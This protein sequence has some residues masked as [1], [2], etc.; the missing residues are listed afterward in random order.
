MWNAEKYCKHG[1]DVVNFREDRKINRFQKVAE[2]FNHML[3]ENKK[4]SDLIL[5]PTV[6]A[7]GQ[8]ETIRFKQRKERQQKMQC[9]CLNGAGEAHS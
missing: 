5:C 8:K 1:L 3:H 2:L 7:A 4:K 6:A 9:V